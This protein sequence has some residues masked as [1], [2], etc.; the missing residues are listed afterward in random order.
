VPE[1]L[2]VD[3]QELNAAELAALID[4]LA[5]HYLRMSGTDFQRAWEAGEFDDDPDR[6]EVMRIAI[7]LPRGG[8]HAAPS[9]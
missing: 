4:G 6:R 8:Q 1:T 9:R 7:L 3:V 5:Q 2:D